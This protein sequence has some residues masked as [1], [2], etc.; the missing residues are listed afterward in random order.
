MTDAK[1]AAVLRALGYKT[2][3][4]SE[5]TPGTPAIVTVK[6]LNIPRSYHAVYYNGSRFMDPNR[7]RE[8]KKYYRDVGPEAIV[9]TMTFKKKVPGGKKNREAFK[10]KREA[11]KKKS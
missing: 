3:T 1:Q 11:F 2:R 10:K 8:G 4:T 6:S 5:M 7:G 9:S